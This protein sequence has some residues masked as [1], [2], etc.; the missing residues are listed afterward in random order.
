MALVAL[1]LAAVL[2]DARRTLDE[3][4]ASV[5][6]LALVSPALALVLAAASVAAAAESGDVAVDAQVAVADLPL[7]PV[8]AVAG[9]AAAAPAAAAF[10]VPGL[11]VAAVR[12]P[13]VAPPV[14]FSHPTYVTPTHDIVQAA[15]VP[16]A[17][18]AVAAFG[19]AVP[20]AV[21]HPPAIAPGVALFAALHLVSVPLSELL[22]VHPQQACLAVVL[23]HLQWFD[24]IFAA[25]T[26]SA[27]L[28]KSC[29]TAADVPLALTVEPHPNHQ[30]SCYLGRGWQLQ[31]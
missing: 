13:P 30:L 21:V 3:F 11:A 5:A 14:A 8:L 23:P 22:S 9:V 20:V 1:F 31:I 29:Q 15:A 16:A 2:G 17:A 28:Y 4:D 26:C 10:V 6:S 7:A 19:I 18:I 12:P 24:P 27:D 25:D